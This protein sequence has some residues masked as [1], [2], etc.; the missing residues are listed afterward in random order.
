MIEF[1]D[2]ALERKHGVPPGRTLAELAA[3]LRCSQCGERRGF[4]ISLFDE[5]G[6]GKLGHSSRVVIGGRSRYRP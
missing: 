3:K 5:K 1:R 2:R 4:R 6:R